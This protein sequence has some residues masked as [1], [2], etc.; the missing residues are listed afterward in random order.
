VGELHGDGLI[1]ASGGDGEY[2]SI[3]DGA[4]G[5]ISLAVHDDYFTGTVQAASGKVG[6]ASGA[7]T[8]YWVPAEGRQ[9]GDLIVDNGGRSTQ[10]GSTPIKSVGRRGITAVEEV[11]AGVWDLTVDGTPWNATNESLGW[12]LQGQEV[13]LDASDEL[14]PLYRVVSNTQSSLRIETADNLSGYL[15]RELI[16]VHTFNT[17]SVTSGASVSFGGDRVYLIDPGNSFYSGNVVDAEIQ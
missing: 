15:G 4:G 10:N 6:Y 16:G 3:S 13:S 5:R 14:A 2:S 8:V 12:G 9:Y 17:L 11:S 1:S 7:G